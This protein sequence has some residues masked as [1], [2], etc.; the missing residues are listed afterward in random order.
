MANPAGSRSL[1]QSTRFVL[2][3]LDEYDCLRRVEE[4]RVLIGRR[5]EEEDE[6][7]EQMI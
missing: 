5:R 1:N 6:K 7:C 4:Q 3:P 2:T